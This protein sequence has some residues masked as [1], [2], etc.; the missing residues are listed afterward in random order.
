MNPFLMP[1]IHVEIKLKSFEILKKGR[2]AYEIQITH[3][4]TSVNQRTKAINSR[5][6]N[7]TNMFIH[8]PNHRPR[9]H[10]K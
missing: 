6:I 1:K 8:Q 3:S 9:R 2:H 7:N 4:Q 5:V 10:S